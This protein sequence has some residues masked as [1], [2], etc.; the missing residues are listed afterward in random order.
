MRA[1]IA[2]EGKEEEAKAQKAKEAAGWIAHKSGDGQVSPSPLPQ[3]ALYSHAATAVALM[4]AILLPKK[5][6]KACWG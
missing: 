5:K 6:T 1:A 2:A 4:P 3:A